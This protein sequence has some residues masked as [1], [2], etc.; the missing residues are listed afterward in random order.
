MNEIQKAEFDPLDDHTRKEP[1]LLRWYRDATK[2]IPAHEITR[3]PF[4]VLELKLAL[5][6]G[7]DQPEWTKPLVDSLELAPV[8]NCVEI[9]ILRRVPA[10]S[11]CRPPRHRRDAC[12]MAWR[13][14]FL[15]ARPGQVGRVI[16]EK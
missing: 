2:G 6:E 11:S 7:E 16:A 10:A 4:A 15:A 12:S 14:R 3:F 13:C 5:A 9:K 8:N 1:T